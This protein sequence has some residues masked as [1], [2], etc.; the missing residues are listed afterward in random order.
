MPPILDPQRLALL[1]DVQAAL[2][3][4]QDPSVYFYPARPENVFLDPVNLMG[5]PS[6]SLPAFVVEPD[7]TGRR[8]YQPAE[9][10]RY[11]F[12]VLITA[13]VDAEGIATDR[14]TVAGEKLLADIERALTVDITRGDRAVDTRLD[15]PVTSCDVGASNMVVVRQPLRILHFR[16][17]GQ[18]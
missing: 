1:R 3:A 12:A 7:N 6:T 14:K 15:E 8:S 10:L 17:Y 5:L 11:E 4:I 9:V 16:Q 18:P 13:R 2:R